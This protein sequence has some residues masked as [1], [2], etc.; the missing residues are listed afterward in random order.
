VAARERVDAQSQFEEADAVDP[1]LPAQASRAE[2]SVGR[3][4]EPTDEMV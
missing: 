3:G 1:D 2:P 4:A